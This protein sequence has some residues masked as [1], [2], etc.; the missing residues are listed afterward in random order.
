M[1]SNIAAVGGSTRITQMTLLFD[2]KAPGFY[3][4]NH[5]VIGGFGV[6][7]TLHDAIAESAGF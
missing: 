3:Y 2:D 7:I 1:E 5:Y 4:N 6:L